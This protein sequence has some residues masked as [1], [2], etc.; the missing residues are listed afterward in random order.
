M[1]F[2]R[3]AFDRQ[4]VLKCGDQRQHVGNELE[5]HFVAG[6][7][8]QHLAETHTGAGVDGRGFL[9]AAEADHDGFHGV[10]CGLSRG[11]TML[12]D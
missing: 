2:D 7:A 5:V 12:Y 9:V 3:Q 6:F 1:A 8:L 4:A 10:E 11:Q